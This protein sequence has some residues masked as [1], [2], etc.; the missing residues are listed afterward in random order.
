MFATKTRQRKVFISFCIG[1]L[2]SGLALIEAASYMAEARSR[3]DIA[4][5]RKQLLIQLTIHN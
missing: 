5:S 4:D 2:T 3:K 1:F